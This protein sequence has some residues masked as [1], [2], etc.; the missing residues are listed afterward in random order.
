MISKR[1][2]YRFKCSRE[3]VKIKS[4]YDDGEGE[5]TDI[6]TTGCAL[7]SLTLAIPQGEKIL[8]SITLPEENTTI[9]IQAL[10][11]RAEGGEIATKFIML[12]QQTIFT[13]QHYFP[14]KLRKKQLQVDNETLPH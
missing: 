9:E 5:L 1:S 13:I 6:S 7:V 3:K 2:A 14:Q 12:E 8:L 11:V 4:T 10:V